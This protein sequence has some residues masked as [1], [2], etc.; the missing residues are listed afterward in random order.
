MELTRRKLITLGVGSV[1]AVVAFPFVAAALTSSPGSVTSPQINVK[2]W[3]F[4][5]GQSIDAAAPPGDSC[6]DAN[7]EVPTMLSWTASGG[8]EKITGYVVNEDYAY[9]GEI[10]PVAQIT[11]QS[12]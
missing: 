8:S 2:P 7:Y 12:T 6:D 4:A 11:T 1:A 9:E 10:I 5:V 3:S